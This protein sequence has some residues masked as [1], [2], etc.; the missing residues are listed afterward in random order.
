MAIKI[1]IPYTALATKTTTTTTTLPPVTG[2]LPVEQSV[3][4]TI[5]FDR[6]EIQIKLTTSGQF[7]DIISVKVSKSFIDT[8]KKMTEVYDVEQYYDEE[9]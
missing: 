8:I 9:E 5:N 7:L 4:R 6:Y 1:G 3:V 2:E